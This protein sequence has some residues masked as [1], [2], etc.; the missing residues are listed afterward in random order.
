MRSLPQHKLPNNLP[1]LQNLIKR[2][3]AAYK[4][5]FLQQF[6]HF[7][8]TLKVYELNPSAMLRQENLESLVMF[9]AQVAHCFSEELSEFPEQLMKAL[10]LH[11]ASM[12]ADT[13]LA[14]IKAL[15]MLRN[16]RLL[17]PVT[18]L[19]VMFELL[20]IQDKKLREFLRLQ[21][22]ADLKRTKDY[23]SRTNS[24]RQKFMFSLLKSNNP[25]VSWIAL[26]IITELYHKGVW[27][28]AKT[29]NVIAETCFSSIT[30]MMVGGLQFFLGKDEDLKDPDSESDSDE[31]GKAGVN[32]ANIREV[33]HA[34][35][36]NKKSRKRK[37]QMAR[38]KRMMKKAKQKEKAP[39]F[40]FSAFHLIHDPQDF[41]E[42]L[43]SQLERLNERFE[44]KLLHIS[45]IS[46]LVGIHELILPPLYSYIQKMLQ[47][48]HK[49]VVQLLT[50]VSQATHPQ[51]PPSSVESVIRTIADHFV[52]ERNS[53]EVMAVGLNAIR[54][55]CERSPHGMTAP[56]L[57]DLGGYRSHR[58]KAV[59]MAAKSLISTF[60]DSMPEL[61][62]KKERGRPTEA[63]VE[64][65]ALRDGT[66]FGQ[67]EARSY[68]P[69]AE[70]LASDEEK[71]GDSDA[72]ESND[73]EGDDDDESE[74]DEGGA[75]GDGGSEDE[76]EDEASG[77]EVEGKEEQNSKESLTSV[78]DSIK[79]ATEVSCSRILS[80]EDFR[81][82]DRQQLAKRSRPAPPKHG[83]GKH[84][85]R[86]KKKQ[87]ETKQDEM[88]EEEEELD[89][90]EDEGSKR[91]YGFVFRKD[92]ELIHSKRPHDKAS[93]LETIRA[94]Q[95]ERD[96]R[97]FVKKL[98][99]SSA[100]ASTS[101]KEKQK[102]KPFMMVR[103]KMKSKKKQSFREKQVCFQV[104][105]LRDIRMAS[106]GGDGFVGGSGKEKAVPPRS[107]RILSVGLTCVDIVIEVAEYPTEDTDQRLKCQRWTRGGN[108]SNT[109][110]VLRCL[111]ADV[112]LV[113]R[114]GSGV[115]A[116]FL[117]KDLST[118]GISCHPS[119]HQGGESACS[120]VILNQSNGS[121]T[122]LAD[123]GQM[124][125]VSKEQLLMHDLSRYTWIHLEGRCTAPDLLVALT[126][127]SDRSRFRIS[128][129]IEKI[130]SWSDTLHEGKMGVPDVILY[131]RDF[132]TSKGG[133]SLEEA[134]PL[135]QKWQRQ[136]SP[137]ILVCAWGD[138]GGCCVD[139]EGVAHLS[140]A[141]SP[142]E[143]IVDTLGAGDTFNAAFI[144]ALNGAWGQAAEALRF[145]CR[146]A[147]TKCGIR[148][149]R[150]L[151]DAS[152]A[153]V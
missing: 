125:E 95:A 41:S 111:G 21:T 77:E 80:Q 135:L 64:Q 25:Q 56:L 65:L 126:T 68:V 58:E 100:H 70:A 6:R 52:T 93:R 5:E 48:H 34:S 129:E 89:S 113:T 133:S 20:V 101:N 71:E 39:S 45:L 119:C 9:L 43:F 139:A 2:D 38:V 136:K 12:H 40:N 57:Q 127:H 79:K 67:L 18:L 112:D 98:Q 26:Q 8:S 50:F 138:Q 124:G 144:F 128:L 103:N 27:K 59:S 116:D 115:F 150:G 92:I 23:D 35:K 22:I 42:K 73:E 99:R 47:P 4:D 14:F 147:G 46:R 87:E 55:I 88:D 11:Q 149:F 75:D 85:G 140:P 130:R 54:S 36:C 148:G 7:E 37:K 153:L 84:G 108:A 114:I 74:D 151:T 122:I 91:P 61:L 143:G 60:R 15:V 66:E 134:V 137:C 72:Q 69:G 117:R 106:S 76:T 131:S 121:R 118:W 51:V 1:Q 49:D 104:E 109:A 96:R 44:I 102:R 32:A 83:R 78:Q 24:E 82:I 110:S 63:S 31:E 105:F 81:R 19:R 141:F 33:M 123:L 107:G 28:D 90:E 16:K 53:S 29:V 145:A 30:K 142:P 3:P 86:Q 132:V 17:S 120:F 152:I 10:R 13:R 97:S 94:N 62:K 146:V